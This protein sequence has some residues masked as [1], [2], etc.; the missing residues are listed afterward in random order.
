MGDHRLSL[1]IE[2]EMH[3]HKAKQEWWINASPSD[4]IPSTVEDWFRLQH[5]AAMR[6]YEDQNAKYWA[7]QKKEKIEK[8]ERDTLARLKAKY[9]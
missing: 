1:K 2:Y 7:E 6:R 5:E 8:E 9:E 3:G 4:W